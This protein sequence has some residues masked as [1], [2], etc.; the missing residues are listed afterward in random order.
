MNITQEPPAETDATDVTFAFATSEAGATVAP[1]TE[2][3]LDDGDFRPC[4]SPITYTDLDDGDHE[5]T[6]RATDAY[7]KQATDSRTWA[8]D[9]IGSNTLIDSAPAA[10]IGTDAATIAFSSPDPAA[11]FECS[12]DGSAYD[13]CTSPAEYSNL[14]EGPHTFRAR[15]IDAAS[16]IDPTP[17][18]VRFRVDL[19]A[20]DSQISSGPGALTN[21][22]TPT[23]EF[24]ADEL[25]STFECRFDAG[26]WEPCSSPLTPAA[27]SEG[28]H[29]LAVR[30]TDLV[31][32]VES[33]PATR[34]FNVDQ[35]APGT[36]IS[37]GP[38]EGTTI[39]SASAT[40]GFD[41]PDP[42]AAAFRCSIDESA[43]VPCQSSSS[44]T[45][46]G[47]ADGDH[48]FSVRSVDGAG[49]QDPAPPVRS[50]R[51][52]TQAPQT[53]IVTGPASVERS[54]EATF[55]FQA[56]DPNATFEC[57]LDQ[58]TYDGCTSPQTYSGLGQGD[59]DFAV[60]AVDP[61]GNADP[62]P[63]TRTWTVDLSDEPLPDRPS[64]PK[65]SCYFET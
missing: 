39:S 32:N 12:F 24:S 26:N 50:F 22:D 48:T 17:A 63:A 60:R 18:T 35:T 36:E 38:T 23:F 5:F 11:T 58:G 43:F 61:L 16:I 49:N 19:T 29:E 47:L 20:P 54:Q 30:A 15:A 25:D 59:H 64:K 2:C 41:S 6:V 1:T 45:Y 21:D 52:D 53:S 57:S 65:K 9:A 42:D 33:D 3:K 44:Q 31:Q 7:G 40:F 10:R 8:I 37:S 28:D 13:P 56:D 27:L 4:G 55:E 51:V 14:D 34:S 46:Q 62:S